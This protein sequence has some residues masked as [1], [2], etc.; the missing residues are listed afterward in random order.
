MESSDQNSFKFFIFLYV[1]YEQLLLLGGIDAFI[2]YPP[3]Y[4][5]PHVLLLYVT[6]MQMITFSL[7]ILAELKVDLKSLVW[8]G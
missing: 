2:H 4:L 7:C 8:K 1:F 3:C 6:C 5:F